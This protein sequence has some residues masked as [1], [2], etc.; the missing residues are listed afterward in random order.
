MRQSIY[1]VLLGCLLFSGCVFKSEQV[2]PGCDAECT[3]GTPVCDELG[4]LCVECVGDSECMNAAEPFCLDRSRCA[5]PTR[6][7]RRSSSSGT[8]RRF[9]CRAATCSACR[10]P[11]TS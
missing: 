2:G 1:T 10:S 11:S 8:A 6:P 4:G 7:S 9:A 3:G 5:A